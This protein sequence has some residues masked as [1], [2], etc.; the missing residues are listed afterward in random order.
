MTIEGEEI[1]RG[2]ENQL[3]ERER[4]SKSNSAAAQRERVN[5]HVGKKNEGAS[6][7][8]IHVPMRVVCCFKVHYTHPRMCVLYTQEQT[9][10]K[11]QRR[12]RPT[13]SGSYL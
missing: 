7:S 2:R 1:K 10:A 4:D 8:R 5:I 13:S 3:R 11:E 9:F 6:V 12:H